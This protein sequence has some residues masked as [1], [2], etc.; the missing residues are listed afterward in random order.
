MCS[1]LRLWTRCLDLI[2][3][4][5]CILCAVRLRVYER[6][7]CLHCNESLALYHPKMHLAHERLWASPIFGELYAMYA[8]RKEGQVQ[9][10]LHAF[11]YKGYREVAELVAEGLL[12]YHPELE[13]ATYDLIL[14]TPI[15]SRHFAERGY[16]QALVLAK[17]LAKP[18]ACQASDK[19]L[20]R[21]AQASSQTHLGKLDRLENIR[22]AFSLSP[23]LTDELSGKRILLVD[24]V[25]TTGATLNAQLELLEQA[26]A[27][28]VDVA[29]AAVSILER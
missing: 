18:L 16:N 9:K 13:Q 25:L 10:L 14:A 29:V 24:D 4:R 6:A 20:L 5:L 11:K 19:H 3:P 27:K 2:Y 17:K 7:V 28:S 8:Y 12:L 26:G 1:N 21:S 23:K 15:S 22:D